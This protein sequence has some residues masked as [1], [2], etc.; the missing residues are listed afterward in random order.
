MD[1]IKEPQISKALIEYLDKLF[2]NA[3]AEL[4]DEMKD[5]FYKSGQ[6]SVY[7]HLKQLYDNQH[8][9]GDT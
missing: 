6:R 2:P 9:K 7:S 8:N 1:N 5:V 3:C 4:K